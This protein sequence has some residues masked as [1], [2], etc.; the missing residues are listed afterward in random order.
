MCVCTCVCVPQE[1]VSR[2]SC[3]HILIFMLLWVVLYIE[4]KQGECFRWPAVF[5]ETDSHRAAVET[6]GSGRAT[7]NLRAKHTAVT[8]KH[9]KKTVVLFCSLCFVSSPKIERQQQQQQEELKEICKR[10]QK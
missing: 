9:T 6:H 7:I 2:H 3:L 1:G 4:N 5:S 10:K 8:H